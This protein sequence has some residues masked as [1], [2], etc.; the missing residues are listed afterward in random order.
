MVSPSDNASEQAKQRLA[1]LEADPKHSSNPDPQAIEE[2]RQGDL[3][4]PAKQGK[5]E[6]DP[7]WKQDAK[8]NWHH[9]EFDQ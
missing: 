1:A 9:P 6:L 8:G 2:T 3:N 7:G 4:D 5:A